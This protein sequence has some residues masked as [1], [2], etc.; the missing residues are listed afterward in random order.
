ML[1][2]VIIYFI[3]GLVFGSFATMAS[4]RLAIEKSLMGRSFCPKCKHQLGVLDLL[5]V[6]TYLFNRGKCRYCKAKISLRY[7]A[8]ELATGLLFVISLLFSSN[9]GESIILCLVSVTLV[10][11]IATDLEHY[12]IPDEIQISLLII[13]VI[14]GIYNSIPVVN[15]IFIPFAYFACATL[16]MEGFKKICKKD[17]LGFG[18]VKFFAVC[19]FFIPLKG[20]A[21][22]LFVSGILG[23]FTALIWKILNKGKLFPFGPS[24]AI[25]L[26]LYLIW[27]KHIHLFY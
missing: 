17:G 16:L 18:D 22:F 25:A 26:Y 14:Y 13:G 5:P 27:G 12:I 20:V 15:M 7:P 4:Y 21:F 11:M 3:F 19:G 10:I 1:T 2:L 23:L 9:I 6:V 24:L 8:I